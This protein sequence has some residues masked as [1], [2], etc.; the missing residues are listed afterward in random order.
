MKKFNKTIAL[1]LLLLALILVNFI[2]GLTRIQSD[3]TENSLYT[4]SDGSRNIFK[5]IE[6][7]ITLQFY[8]SRSAS[9]APVFLKNYATLVEDLLHQYERASRGKIRLEVINPRPDSEE[10]ESAIRIGISSQ[11]LP[12]GEPLFFGLAAI[13]ADREEI[14]PVFSRQ[15]EEFL[16]FDISKLIHKVQL[17]DLPKL[18]IISSL[19]VFGEPASPF[20]PA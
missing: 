17:T 2:G 16:E 12:S 4:L 18:G 15:R 8:F 7:P 10:E 5:E 19:D 1:L 11:P 13:Q 9:S 20:G 3:W 14:L 6:E